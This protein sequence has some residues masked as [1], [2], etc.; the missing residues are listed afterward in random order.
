MLY[1][2]KSKATADLIMLGEGAETVL[3]LV[4]KKGQSKGIIE[5]EE[6]EAAIN[7]LELAIQNNTDGPTKM[8]Q[9]SAEHSTDK[10]LDPVTLHQRVIPFIKMLQECQKSNHVIVWGV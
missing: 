4:G 2:F 6:M 10:E 3:T 7:S 5:V 8:Q 9:S 1:K